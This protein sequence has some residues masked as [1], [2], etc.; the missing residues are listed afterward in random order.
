MRI[1]PGRPPWDY[2]RPGEPGSRAG[3]DPIPAPHPIPPGLAATHRVGHQHTLTPSVPGRWSDHRRPTPG[4]DRAAPGFDILRHCCQRLPPAG[5]AATRSFVTSSDQQ[6]EASSRTSQQITSALP[7]A[8]MC[9]WRRRARMTHR[10]LAHIGCQERTPDR[11]GRSTRG[12]VVRWKHRRPTLDAGGSVTAVSVRAMGGGR[13][14]TSSCAGTPTTR[15][16]GVRPG[17]VHVLPS[18]APRSGC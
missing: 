16:C 17:I 13:C 2:A 7:A 18:R 9:I 10:A 11:S 14:D 5:T 1:R 3:R 15:R 12:K 4:R 6:A 8:P